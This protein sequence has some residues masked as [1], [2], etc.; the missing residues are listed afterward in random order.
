MREIEDDRSVFFLVGE[1]GR[2]GC[3]R[4]PYLALKLW[5]WFQFLFRSTFSQ[6][7]THGHSLLDNKATSFYFLKLSA[8]FNFNDFVMCLLH[9]LEGRMPRQVTWFGRLEVNK[10]VPVLTCWRVRVLIYYAHASAHASSYTV[11][12]TYHH[13]S[14][15]HSFLGD[16][17]TW[18]HAGDALAR[19]LWKQ[20]SLQL[21]CN[22]EADGELIFDFHEISWAPK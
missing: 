20:D 16:D 6:K 8:V 15:L 18:M 14:M 13:I 4:H 9:R 5:R 1:T 17:G 22:R 19:V 10:T 11:I 2:Q 3:Q 7:T 12:H 21:A